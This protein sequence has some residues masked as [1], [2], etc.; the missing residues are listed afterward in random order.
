[1]TKTVL[2]K[3]D[4]VHYFVIERLKHGNRY[5]QLFDG[6]IVNEF[7]SLDLMTSKI[8]SMQRSGFSVT[9]EK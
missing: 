7:S 8:Q 3:N 6:E 4:L 1:M 9:F 5:Y 2:T